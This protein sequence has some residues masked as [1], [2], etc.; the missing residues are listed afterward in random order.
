M[1]PTGWWRS[2]STLALSIWLM[3]V[4]WS[5]EARRRIVIESSARPW[6]SLA[7]IATVFAEPFFYAGRNGF[8]RLKKERSVRHPDV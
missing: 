4:E 8:K 3:F 5:L 6:R 7:R 1:F 2:I